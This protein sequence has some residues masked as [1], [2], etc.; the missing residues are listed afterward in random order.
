MDYTNK[1]PLRVVFGDFTLGVHGNGFDYIL[2]YCFY[3]IHNEIIL[4]V[5][6]FMYFSG[7]V[8]I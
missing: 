3:N 8:C 7:F 1:M 5:K 2:Y 6:L 4:T